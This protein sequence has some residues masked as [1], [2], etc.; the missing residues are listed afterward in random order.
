MS[1]GVEDYVEANAGV[2]L[3]V[4]PS[5]NIEAGYRYIDMAGKD[6][7]RDNTLAD[8]AYAGVNFRF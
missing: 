3:N 7:N 2:R 8:G 6:G 5:L 1:S 4:L